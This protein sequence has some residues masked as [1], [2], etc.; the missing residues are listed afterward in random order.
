M[1]RTK[2][3]N[4]NLIERTD[5]F[6]PDAL[7]ENTEQLEAVLSENLERMDAAIIGKG[8]CSVT[9]GSFPGNGTSGREIKLGFTPKFLIV[10]GVDNGTASI[11]YS[12]PSWA[13]K[14]AGWQHVESSV[15]LTSTGFRLSG[16]AFNVTGLTTYYVAFS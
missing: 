2:K 6:T 7:N 12:T 11:N 4:L 13:F 3:W 5:A 8:T 1:Q 9:T 16:T 15:T 14:V 10:K